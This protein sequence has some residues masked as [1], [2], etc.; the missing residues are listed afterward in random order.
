[1]VFRLACDAPLA[2]LGLLRLPSERI[3]GGRA[4]V[5]CRERGIHALYFWQSVARTATGLL[6]RL[7]GGAEGLGV[8]LVPLIALPVFGERLSLDRLAGRR[9]IVF[10]IVGLSV[11]PSADARIVHLG[12]A[13]GTAWAVVTGL[14][15]AAYSLVDKAGVARL[16][17]MS[18]IALMGLA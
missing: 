4:A 5:R 10:G 7:P 6:A 3:A 2:P 17:P 12:S 16:H 1:V 18:Y 15:I 8:A 13:P 9:I 14:T 11:T